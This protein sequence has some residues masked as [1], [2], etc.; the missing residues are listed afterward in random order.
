MTKAVVGDR[1]RASNARYD[2]MEG[3]VI[4]GSSYTL[5][6]SGQVLY[7]DFVEIVDYLGFRRYRSGLDIWVLIYSI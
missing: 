1:G 5:L 3:L 2:P 6:S 7:R 4:V